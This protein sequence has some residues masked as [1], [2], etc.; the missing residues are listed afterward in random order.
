MNFCTVLRKNINI[1]I[2]R[3][4]ILKNFLFRQSMKTGVFSVISK[5]LQQ[6]LPILWMHTGSIIGS[7]NQSSATGI[8]P[9]A[10]N[11]IF[12]YELMIFSMISGEN[13]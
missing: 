10:K 1:M 9:N 5:I 11:L 4:Y 6:K 8:T 12:F 13:E 3:K 2:W 7:K